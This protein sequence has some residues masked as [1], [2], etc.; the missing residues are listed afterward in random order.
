VC[1][2][3]LVNVCFAGLKIC[4]EKLEIK[5]FDN[6]CWLDT[7]CRVK[8]MNKEYHVLVNIY[9][10]GMTTEIYN[11]VAYMTSEWCTN[12]LVRP[13]IRQ[14]GHFTFTLKNVLCYLVATRVM[15]I[16]KAQLGWYHVSIGIWSTLIDVASIVFMV[17][18]T[19]EKWSLADIAGYMLPPIYSIVFVNVNVICTC[20]CIVSWYILKNG[21]E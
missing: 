6:W 11:I 2:Y 18:D 17:I 16:I 15:Q 3:K 20:N 21:N 5:F 13:A 1:T 12:V 14:T 10:L 8:S 9:C 7:S 19:I 4:S